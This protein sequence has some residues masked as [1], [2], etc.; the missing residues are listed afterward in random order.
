MGGKGQQIRKYIRNRVPVK[1]QLMLAGKIARLKNRRNLK[2]YRM[3]KRNL[4]DYFTV[5]IYRVN[6]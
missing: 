4:S 5:R 3:G 6:I 1:R 2:T